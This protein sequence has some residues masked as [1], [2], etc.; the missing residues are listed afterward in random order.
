MSTVKATLA[1]ILTDYQHFL[2]LLQK[3][4]ISNAKGAIYKAIQKAGDLDRPNLQAVLLLKLGRFYLDKQGG[5]QDAAYA[6]TAGGNLLLQKSEFK[7]ELNKA[8]R[9]LRNMEKGYL[10]S[11]DSLPDGYQPEAEKDLLKAEKD[12]FLAVKLLVNGS[13][14]LLELGQDANALTTFESAASV[15]SLRQNPVLMAKIWTN[16]AE[17]HR[18]LDHQA[19]AE[20]FLQQAQ[21]VFEENK[22]QVDL[23]EFLA[24]YGAL[25]SDQGKWEEAARLFENAVNL[26]E[27]AEDDKGYSRTLVRLAK[28]YLDRKKFAQAKPHLKAALE[29]GKKVGDKSNLVFAYQ[30]LARCYLEENNV[31]AAIP[32]L[33]GCLKTLRYVVEA[34]IETEQGK[35]SRISSM[36]WSLNALI[37]SYLSLMQSDDRPEKIE[38][39]ILKKIDELHG[40]ILDDVIS[41]TVS[42]FRRK[43]EIELTEGLGENIP[44]SANQ[45]AF[46]DFIAPR[47]RLIDHPRRDKVTALT[48]IVYHQTERRLAIVY[49]RPGEKPIVVSRKKSR[50]KLRQDVENL[51][52]SLKVNNRFRGSNGRGVR[53][54]TDGNNKN[55]R[56]LLRRLYQELIHPIASLL[57]EPDSL[58][59][60]EPHDA[61]FMA[62]FGALLNEQE[63][64]LCDKYALLISSSEQTTATLRSYQPYQND[65]SSAKALI[66]G[67]P[68]M[69]EQIVVNGQRYSGFSELPGAEEEAAIIHKLFKKENVDYL[70]DELANESAIRTA[71]RESNVIHF[72]T[73]GIAFANNP[74]YSLLMVAGDPGYVTARTIRNWETPADLV[75]LSACQTAL[76]HLAETEG[77]IG[78]SR[79]FFIAGAR[80]VVAGLWSVDD[81]ATVLL[82]THFYQALFDG[83][84]V[85]E[86]MRRAKLALKSQPD[87]ANPF[88]WAGFV[89][90]GA[91]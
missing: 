30:G 80:T 71:I 4:D 17:V 91:E 12:P 81:K 64:Y 57:P 20:T 60:I 61:L 63:E 41:G 68:K 10:G 70:K 75:V 5:I 42:P 11:R 66:V 39:L 36:Q 21:A 6:F 78:L 67:N 88:Y 84:S 15:K 48:R 73:H 22:E 40:M 53:S 52:C 83:K 29:L 27:K 90:M 86:A 1:E 35:I 14:C 47:E 69:E 59:V 72:A 51:I 13:N 23:K 24:I 77:V 33:E 74:M 55:S 16:M 56:T 49:D 26:Y 7:V 8:I 58:L 85:P 44:F 19:Q 2:D 43:E 76:G 38:N 87:Y 31:R 34:T 50:S 46:A 32:Y 18:R 65:L 25:R 89:A 79:S 82:M 37:D 45:M 3:N 62:P 9:P 28:L 54:S